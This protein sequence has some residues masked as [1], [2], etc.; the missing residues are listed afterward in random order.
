M[1]KS[2]NLTNLK[3]IKKN[4]KVKSK[5]F[6]GVYSQNIITNGRKDVMFYFNFKDKNDLNI[7]GLPKLRWIKVGKK[8]EGIS[9]EIANRQRNSQIS[10][11]NN[12]KDIT[13]VSIKKKNKDVLRFQTLAE[14]Y[15]VDKRITKE[16]MSRYNIH[17]KPLFGNM[18]CFNITKKQVK[19]FLYKYSEKAAPATVNAVRETMTA[20]FNHSIKEYELNRIN[21]CV[22]IPRLKTDN[23]R[24]RYLSTEEIK[25]LLDVV[26]HNKLI[27]LTVRLCLCT[28]ARITSVI[29]IQKKDLNF[30][31]GVVT[32]K[33]FKT[34]STYR[35]F[36]PTDLVEFLKDYT[37]DMKLNEYVLAITEGKK[38]TFPNIRWRLKPILDDLFNQELE[39]DDRKNRVVIH[40]FRHTFASHLAINGT[41]IFTVQKLLD[42]SKIDQTLRYAKLSPNS[43][44][45]NVEQLYR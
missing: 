44:Q 25:L 21:P 20:I 18:D 22:G 10:E 45:D 36:L 26:S 29:N 30:I 17:I 23:E 40:T 14:R 2:S 1:E 32:I 5:K 15:F 12:G 8:S 43:G 38:P 11:M 4:P 42:H 33:N 34:N 16:R 28:G 41:P 27:W 3:G 19:E 7:K 13:L 9:L 37:K 31:N 39:K 24:E 35:G 6:T